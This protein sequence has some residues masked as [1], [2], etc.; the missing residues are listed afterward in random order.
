MLPLVLGPGDSVEGWALYLTAIAA[1]LGAVVYLLRALVKAG[2]WL[3]RGFLRGR[4][5]LDLLEHELTPNHGSSI[6]D[7]V[8]AMAVQLGHAQR[9]LDEIERAFKDHLLRGRNR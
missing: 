9:R 8:T 2:R 7:D 3:R 1:G 6:K 5:V 4:E